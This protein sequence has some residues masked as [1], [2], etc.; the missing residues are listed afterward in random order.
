MSLSLCIQ[1]R[2]FARYYGA[3]FIPWGVHDPPRLKLR[4]WRDWTRRLE[5]TANAFPIDEDG[6][7][8]QR[9]YIAHGRLAQIENVQF[10][11]TV[12]QA[13]AVALAKHRGRARS[14]W[15][16]DGSDKPGCGQIRAPDEAQRSAMK[17]LADLHAKADRMRGSADLVSRLKRAATTDQWGAQLTSALPSALLRT[18]SCSANVADRAHG[19]DTAAA[20]ERLK[21]AWP[22]AAEPA[23]RTAAPL[24]SFRNVREINKALL[25]PLP[26]R[27]PAPASALG[28]MASR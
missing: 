12:N 20:P 18:G 15:K 25:E 22:A 7:S 16:D 13:T 6:E 24:P 3:I 21:R 26:P 10:G 28:D 1:Q 19:Q 4:D 9:R 11:F 8:R 2:E 23:N 5:A 14:L 17:E 27:G